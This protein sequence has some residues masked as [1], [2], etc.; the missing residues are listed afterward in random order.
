MSRITN[1]L[2]NLLN[3]TRKRSLRITEPDP[4]LPENKDAVTVQIKKAFLTSGYQLSVT[5]VDYRQVTQVSGRLR[6][7]S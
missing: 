3:K 7:N 6:G 1:K 2:A 4:V 5:I